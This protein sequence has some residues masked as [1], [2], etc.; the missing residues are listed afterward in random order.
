MLV[1]GSTVKALDWGIVFVG[2]QLKVE[3]SA[4]H[5]TAMSGI[6]IEAIPSTA[7]IDHSEITGAASSVEA[8]T[9]LI[10][11]TRLNGGPVSVLLAATCAGVYDESFTFYAS[12]CP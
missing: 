10:G 5:A 3:R 8:G 6:G 4:I 1:S 7:T 11:A 2:Q 12:T 9:S